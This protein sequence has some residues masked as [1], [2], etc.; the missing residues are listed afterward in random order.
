MCV[1]CMTTWTVQE[2]YRG[3][4]ISNTKIYALVCIPIGLDCPKNGDKKCIACNDAGTQFV[5][6]A[7]KFVCD[8]ICKCKHGEPV[9]TGDPACKKAGDEVCRVCAF[10]YH[11]PGGK[12][13]GVCEENKC[14]CDKK[15]GLPAL[16]PQCAKHG[17]PYCLSCVGL[18][19]GKGWVSAGGGKCKAVCNCE[20]GTACSGPAKCPQPKALCCGCEKDKYLL[21]AGKCIPVFWD[22]NGVGLSGHRAVGFKSVSDRCQTG[23][24]PVSD[25]CQTSV[26]PV[27]DQCQ[28]PY[29]RSPC[30][31]SPSSSSQAE[32][33][34]PCHVRCTVMSDAQKFPVGS[35]E[36]PFGSTVLTEIHEN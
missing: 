2:R 16:G 30:S 4:T 18:K 11:L 12:K 28:V 20:H 25:Q 23:V 14:K 5:L 33:M 32:S 3:T 31:H 34:S 21:R 24:R 10:G 6:N 15:Q 17:A 36:C 19:D 8:P 7:D 26:R 9:N 22:G 29:L 27:S 35:A 1:V 13:T